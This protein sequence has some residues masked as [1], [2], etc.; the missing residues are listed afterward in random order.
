MSFFRKIVDP[1][2]YRRKTLATQGGAEEG[3]TNGWF[4]DAALLHLFERYHG[5]FPLQP[6]SYATVRDYCD[7]FDHLRALATA[8]GDLKDSQRPWT[9]KAVLSRLPRGSHLLEI[10]AGKPLVADLLNRLGYQVWIVDPYDGSGNGPQE[11]DLFSK[12]YPNLRFVRDHFTD[13]LPRLKEYSF[14][15]IFSISVLEHILGNALERGFAGMKKF[16]KPDGISIHAVD[17]V[18]RGA[19]AGEHLGHLKRIVDHLG[20]STGALDEL[21]NEMSIDPEAYYLSAESHN[22]WRNGVPY[23][24]F[25]MRVCVSIQLVAEARD[26]R[27]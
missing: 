5:R 27:G 16:L 10:G 11:Y 8:N 17:H 23:D 4:D 24:Q 7:S 9:L 21:L 3:I 19:G 12:Q 20:L 2:R 18:H 26:I 13:G 22:R 25:P 15:C 14:D 6:M 1:L